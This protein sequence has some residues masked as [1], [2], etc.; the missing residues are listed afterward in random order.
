MKVLK[1]DRNNLILI[2]NEYRKAIAFVCFLAMLINPFAGISYADHILQENP[3]RNLT[4]IQEESALPT[5]TE[6]GEETDTA[7]DAG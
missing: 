6:K 4:S 7:A 3:D 5:N 2:G 1:R